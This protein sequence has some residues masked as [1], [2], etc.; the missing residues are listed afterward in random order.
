[1]FKANVL[2]KVHKYFERHKRRKFK[3]KT[4]PNTQSEF[5]SSPLIST[6]NV[7][8]V[9]FEDVELNFSRGKNKGKRIERICRWKE[10][11][12]TYRYARTTSVYAIKYVWS[13][14][15]ES[16]EKKKNED[17]EDTFND[18]ADGHYAARFWALKRW[19]NNLI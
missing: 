10:N 8:W 2:I 5:S 9:S 13:S 7:K 17:L 14:K 6:S 4:N 12:L 18:L 3:S 19:K 11:S 15:N 16:S 1:M